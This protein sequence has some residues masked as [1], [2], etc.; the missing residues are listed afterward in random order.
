MIHLHNTIFK[1]RYY[2]EVWEV[3]TKFKGQNRGKRQER[4]KMRVYNNY[5]WT[6]K[7]N[8]WIFFVREK[9]ENT[10]IFLN[11]DFCW[12]FLRNKIEH[13]KCTLLSLNSSFP[14]KKNIYFPSSSFYPKINR[15]RKRKLK[16]WIYLKKI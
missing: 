5:I 1:S 8:T 13:Y 11:E 9:K 15:K 3:R 4:R 10:I 14:F 16:P 6:W 7:V 12:N 2:Q